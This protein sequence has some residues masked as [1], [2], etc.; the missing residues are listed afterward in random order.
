MKA[1]VNVSENW[2]IGAGGDLLEH[3]PED[4]KFFRETTKG[5]VI[6]MGRR[7]LL[8]FPGGH[9]LKN[10]TN[11]VLTSRRESIDPAMMDAINLDTTKNTRLIIAENTDEVLRLTKLY[12]PD[13]VY[14]V[15][16]EAVYRE[17][18]PYC[19]E[20]LVTV[21]DSKKKADTFFP[22]LN[23]LENWKL[24]KESMTHEFEGIKYRFTTYIN[25]D[26]K[27]RVS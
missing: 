18:L 22:D 11:I 10:R 20:A 16:G 7:T 17:F 1:I 5:K 4:M 21:N 14:V 15:G 12:N 3:I 19:S 24:K 27:D 6:I 23:E 13:D 9:P 2:G 26:F 8:S 25:T